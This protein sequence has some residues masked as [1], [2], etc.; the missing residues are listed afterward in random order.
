MIDEH[1]DDDRPRFD[2]DDEHWFARPRR[3]SQRPTLP[4]PSMPAPAALDD[5]IADGWFYDV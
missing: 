3:P 4:A 5:S 1:S 2:A